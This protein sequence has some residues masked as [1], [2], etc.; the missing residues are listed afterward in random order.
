VSRLDIATG[1][2]ELWKELLPADASG[3]T[4]VTSP[5]PTPD[6]KYYVYTYIRRLSDLYVAEGLK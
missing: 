1:N 6:G 3:V 4:E 5:L 2:R